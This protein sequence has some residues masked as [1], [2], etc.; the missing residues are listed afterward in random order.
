MIIA[1]VYKMVCLYAYMT[2]SLRHCMVKL[3][4]LEKDESSLPIY[5]Y[6]LSIVQHHWAISGN[7]LPSFP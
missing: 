4:F 5:Q 1:T 7:T 2:P 6:Y 3:N